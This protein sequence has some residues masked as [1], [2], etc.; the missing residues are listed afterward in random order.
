[1]RRWRLDVN[2][3]SNDPYSTEVTVTCRLPKDY[4]QEVEA[5]SKALGDKDLALTFTRCL[6][7]GVS[8]EITKYHERM[9]LEN[10]K[11]TDSSDAEQ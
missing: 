10:G 11:R 7:F 9:K 4:F 8:G 6:F 3:H 2:D 5:I 1:M